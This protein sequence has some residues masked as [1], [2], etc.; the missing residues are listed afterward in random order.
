M[1]DNHCVIMDK[2]PSNLLIEKIEMTS[3]I[4][5]PLT[6]K[7]VKK[8]NTTQTVDKRKSAQL[9]TAFTTES[10]RSTNEE[11]SV[12]NI[13]KGENDAEMKATFQSQT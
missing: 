12:R 2:I 8:K 3:N 11:N 5:F 13:K 9:D 7:S 4:M 6:L 1:E 10:M